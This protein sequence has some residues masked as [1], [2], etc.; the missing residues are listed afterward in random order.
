MLAGSVVVGT[1]H[2]AGKADSTRRSYDAYRAEHQRLIADGTIRVSGAA[3]TLTR[4]LVSSSP[5]SAG[6]D[7]LGRACNGRR[8]W[9]WEGGTFADWESRGLE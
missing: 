2:G 4:D 7:A 6:T 1:W 9:T 8:E 3:G 5:S